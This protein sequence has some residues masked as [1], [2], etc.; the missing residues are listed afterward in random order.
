MAVDM[1]D[2]GGHVAEVLLTERRFEDPWGWGIAGIVRRIDDPEYKQFELEIASNKP[3]AQKMRRGVA[4]AI[5]ADFRPDNGFRSGKKLS[6]REAYERMV[7]QAAEKGEVVIDLYD[8]R[9]KKEGI[10]RILC[11]ELSFKGET[12]VRIQGKEFDLSTPEGRAGLMDHRLWEFQEGGVTKEKTT[13]LYKRR[14]DGELETD[15]YG[16][17]VEQILGGQNI[18]D[19]LARLVLREAKDLSAFVEQRK[20]EV[21]DSSGGI[22]SGSTETGFPSP[23]DNAE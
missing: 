8:L 10:A 5:Y 3:D 13:P 9:E 6:K 20:A 15:D 19:A 21:L 1:D 7:S 12:L 22:Q 18:G 16:E 4:E 14:P 23:S 2:L 17:P 11:R